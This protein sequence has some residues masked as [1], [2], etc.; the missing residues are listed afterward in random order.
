M[1]HPAAN[2]AYWST[3]DRFTLTEAGWLWCGLE[4][5]ADG[6]EFMPLLGKGIAPHP[7]IPNLPAMGQ[8]AARAMWLDIKESRLVILT[9]HPDPRYRIPREYLRAWAIQHGPWRPR[10]L[11]PDEIATK[12]KRRVT[13]RADEH[14]RWA[15][16][17]EQIRRERE[18]NEDYELG[19]EAMA[20]EV[21]ER[22]NLR[23]SVETVRKKI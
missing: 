16:C 17:A 23:E 18:R 15:R 20:R 7:V 5:P 22:L 6:L 1:T 10:F 9:D 12:P 3:V 2:F 19:K 8:R 21:I 11:F 13:E 4:P 14:A